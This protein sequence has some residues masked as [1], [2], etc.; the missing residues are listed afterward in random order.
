[1]GLA[2]MVVERRDWVDAGLDRIDLALFWRVMLPIEGVCVAASTLVVASTFLPGEPVADAVVGVAV[3][4][5]TLIGIL[6]TIA[7][8]RRLRRSGDELEA[9]PSALFRFMPRW[10][11]LGLSALIAAGLVIAALSFIRL[12]GQPEQVGDRYYLRH[13]RELTEV[14]YDEYVEHRKIHVRV[15]IGGIGVFAAIVF[16][17][18]LGHR[19]RSRSATVDLD[20]PAPVD[21]PSAGPPP[22][23]DHPGGPGGS[24]QAPGPEDPWRPPA[25]TLRW[26]PS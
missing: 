3:F 21:L 17:A 19:Q 4:P 9:W 16:G 14:R 24:D 8:E 23:L 26:P 12:D 6:G 15:L 20:T 25:E 11:R 5:C 10:Q 22:P 13:K 1:M 7:S 2:S 18:G